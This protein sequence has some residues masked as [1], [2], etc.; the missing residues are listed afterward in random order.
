MVEH[1]D[2]L[3]D[4]A[5]QPPGRR[6]NMFERLPHELDRVRLRRLRGDDL[7]EFLAYRSDPRVAEYQGWEPM[8]AAGAVSFLAQHA[9]HAALAPGE[10]RQLGIADKGNDALIGDIGLCLSTDGATIEFGISLRTASQGQGLG[11]ECVRGLLRLL[12]LATPLEAVVAHVDSRNT[13][14]IA[15][16]LKAGLAQVSRRDA[17]ER[18]EA[19]IELGFSAERRTVRVS[20]AE[21]A[22]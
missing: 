11:T 13:A 4:R 8:V 14:C 6:T 1:A 21:L 9:A 16:L 20:N 7:D 15:M 18:G 19:W 3:S 10:W 17:V 5:V 2:P 22:S 12:F